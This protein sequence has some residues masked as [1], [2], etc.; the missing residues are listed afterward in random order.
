MTEPQCAQFLIYKMGILR[1][2]P[3][4]LGFVVTIKRNNTYKVL[5][6]VPD[7]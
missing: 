7:T 3:T 2:V 1:V 5:R 4:S 6:T